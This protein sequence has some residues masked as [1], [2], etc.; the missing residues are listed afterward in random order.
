MVYINFLIFDLKMKGA[1]TQPKG[2]AK[3]AANL[4]PKWPGI[5]I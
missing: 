4:E 2:C 1:A 3:T 5:S